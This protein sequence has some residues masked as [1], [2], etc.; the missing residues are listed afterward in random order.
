MMPTIE[1]HKVFEKTPAELALRFAFGGGITVATHLVA[2]AFGPVVAGLF[3]AFPALLP[4]SLTLIRRHAGPEQAAEDARGALAGC[5]ALAVF[6][7]VVWWGCDAD[8]S[9][10]GVLAAAGA[11]WLTVAVGSWWL[12]LT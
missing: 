5:V 2:M 8:H 6:A 1:P 12:V 10:A 7:A 3:L 9:P 4:A 11:A